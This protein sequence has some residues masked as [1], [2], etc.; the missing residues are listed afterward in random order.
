M[1]F[2]SDHDYTTDTAEAVQETSLADGAYTLRQNGNIG[3]STGV[4]DAKVKGVDDVVVLIDG[5]DDDNDKDN[6]QVMGYKKI[7][8]SKDYGIS[9]SKDEDNNASEDENPKESNV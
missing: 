5:E 6:N 8:K 7:L 2:E 9:N 3:S 4:L 1:E